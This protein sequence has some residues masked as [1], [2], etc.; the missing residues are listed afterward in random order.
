MSALHFS[1][2]TNEEDTV[3]LSNV[4]TPEYEETSASSVARFNFLCFLGRPKKSVDSFG[5]RTS[6][7]VVSPILVL[8]GRL[9]LI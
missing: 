9:R 8:L 3:S 6:S 5:A 1:Y 2:L 4:S 7:A